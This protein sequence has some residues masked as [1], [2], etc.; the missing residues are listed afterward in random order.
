MNKLD[1]KYQEG[2][3][4]G[5][6]EGTNEYY[7]GAEAGVGRS[8]DIRRKPPGQRWSGAELLAAKGIPNFPNPNEEGAEVPMNPG[9]VPVVM[10]SPVGVIPAM[11]A[12]PLAPVVARKRVYITQKDIRTFGWIRGSPRCAADMSNRPSTMAHPGESRLRVEA[13]LNKTE[14]GRKRF[15]VADERRGAELMNLRP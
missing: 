1:A 4:L 10:E 12:A 11:P 5:I 2:T 9:G 8:A 7:I 6:K 3:F 13:A 14:E 15:R